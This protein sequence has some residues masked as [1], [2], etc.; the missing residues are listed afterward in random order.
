MSATNWQPGGY[1]EWTHLEDGLP[2]LRTALQGKRINDAELVPY[3]WTA[4]E[5]ARQMRLDAL[6]CWMGW[7]LIQRI[8]DNPWTSPPSLEDFRL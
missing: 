3:V 2:K 5:K 4:G 1:V 6:R 8:H 7:K